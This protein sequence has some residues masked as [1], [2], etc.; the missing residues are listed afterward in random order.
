MSNE[1]KS[2]LLG[3]N[4]STANQRLRKLIMWSLVKEV[5]KDTCFRCGEQ[6]EDVDDLSIEHKEPWQGTNNPR[7]AF[8]DLKNIA[9]SH[10]RCNNRQ[11]SPE[12]THCSEGHLLVGDNIIQ[13]ARGERVCR[14]CNRVQALE[15]WHGRGY[16]DRRRERRMEDRLK[17]GQR[18]LKPLI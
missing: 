1:D 16:A 9:F 12:R 15:N 2:A 10:L 6:I 3:L 4:F 14:E 13:K 18:S 8:F 17:V 7:A 11:P 5:G